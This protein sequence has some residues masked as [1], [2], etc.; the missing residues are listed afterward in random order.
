[1]RRGEGCG[2]W[3]REDGVNGEGH[4]LRAERVGKTTRLLESSRLAL[5]AG[6]LEINI[7][8][9]ETEGFGCSHIDLRKKKSGKSKIMI[10]RCR[11]DTTA[12]FFQI[13]K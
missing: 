11:V 4:W 13:K 9:G 6:S 1:M 7:F 5:K 10:S 3:F 2:A 12:Q 8:G